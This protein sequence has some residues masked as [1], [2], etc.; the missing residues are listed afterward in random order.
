MY[1]SIK[2][3]SKYLKVLNNSILNMQCLPFPYCLVCFALLL[4]IRIQISSI[5]WKL[6]IV[7][8]VPF[9]HIGSLSLSAI[10]FLNKL[11]HLF[12]SLP[13][14]AYC[15]L[16]SWWHFTYFYLSYVSYKLV[17]RGLI[18]YRLDFMAGILHWWFYVFPLAGL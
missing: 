1:I 15:W 13:W 5:Q 11:A 3:L 6:L 16:H 10:Y 12:W 14:I 17:F 8:L 18:R 2:S 4:W 7:I 9:K